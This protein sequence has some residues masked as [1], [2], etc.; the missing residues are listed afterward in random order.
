M[1]ADTTTGHDQSDA[2]AGV[3][4]VTAEGLTLIV[5]SAGTQTADVAAA[6]A[7]LPARAVVTDSRTVYRCRE[8]CDGIAARDREHEHFVTAFA[9][10]AP[11]PA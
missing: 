6:F 3:D 2:T 4:I 1:P 7:D 9:I 5:F 10:S 11:D 8:S